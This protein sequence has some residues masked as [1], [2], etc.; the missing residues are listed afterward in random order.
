MKIRI[1][2]VQYRI[3]DKKP[4]ENILI[5]EDYVRK[6]T[7]KADIIIFPE[8]SISGGLPIEEG[9]DTNGDYLKEF[10]RMASKYN[11]DIIPGTI[12]EESE[13]L[14]NTAYYISS[15]GVVL[16]RYEK[17]NLWKTEK[18]KIIPGNNIVV[19]QTD[20]GIVGMSICWD[21][22]DST[23][24]H[25]MALQGARI[26]YCPS[27]WYK[28]TMM[29]IHSNNMDAQKM[30]VN[31]LCQ[32]RAVENGIIIAY[33]NGVGRARIGE[34]H[35]YCIGQSQITMPVLGRIAY[36]DGDEGMIIS[37]ID[38]TIIDEARNAYG[39][40]PINKMDK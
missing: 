16:G 27:L 32:A 1:A 39:E 10:I 4:K 38:T 15:K 22:M 5:I 37:D 20:Y 8:Y 6:A 33:S 35:D 25:N 2:L 18:E 9:I 21:L 11:I 13:G 29:N 36:M 19:F 3:N 23:I 30:H 17:K 34:S 28:G 12:I 31:S 24:Y 14:R 7:G 26:V 40:L